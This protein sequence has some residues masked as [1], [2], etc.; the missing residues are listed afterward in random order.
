MV[1]KEVRTDPEGQNLSVCT[2]LAER[3]G[4]TGNEKCRELRRLDPGG[5]AVVS[6]A[7]GEG[8]S[9]ARNGLG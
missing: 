1:E 7:V 2:R 5:A 4:P 6:Q 9:I 8:S 3:G